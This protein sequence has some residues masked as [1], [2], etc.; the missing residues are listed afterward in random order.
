MIASLCRRLVMALLALSVS[1]GAF[2]QPLQWWRSAGASK[3]LGLTPEQSDQIDTIF[4]TSMVELRRQKDE[5]DTVEANLSRLIENNAD[6]PQVIAQIDRVETARAALNKTRTLM[7]LH[8]RQVLT[9]DQRTRLNAMRDRGN[10]DQRNR[11]RDQRPR[12]G[13][14]PDAGGD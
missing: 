4:Q 10:R 8:M 3:E 6:E 11:E 13:A 9:P 7:L 2:A 14:K 1:A 5:L 12:S